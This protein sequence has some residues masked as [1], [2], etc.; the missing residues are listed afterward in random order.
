MSARLDAALWD[1]VRMQV[2]LRRR[3]NELLQATLAVCSHDVA[4]ERGLKV[5]GPRIA[6]GQKCC[7]S[8]KQGM[9][10]VLRAG[11]PEGVS[12]PAEGECE[13]V[14]VIVS[15]SCSLCHFYRR[16]SQKSVL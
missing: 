16:A 10:T 11:G 15:P 1:T 3:T 2:N 12:H 8:N 4:E 7:R 14:C 9:V 5:C 13:G 6:F